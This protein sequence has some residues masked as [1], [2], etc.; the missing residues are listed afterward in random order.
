MQVT[1]NS[2]FNIYERF[3]TLNHLSFID[4]PGLSEM[5]KGDLHS[6]IFAYDSRMQLL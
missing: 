5:V 6:T 2:N 1:V 3:A 4:F